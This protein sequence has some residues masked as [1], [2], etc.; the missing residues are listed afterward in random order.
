M[1]NGF[2]LADMR[3]ALDKEFAPC[4][5]DLGDEVV[6]LRNLMRVEDTTRT[7]VM[8]ALERIDTLKG[9]EDDEERQQTPEEI[10]QMSAAITE[11]LSLLPA[12]GK[13]EKLVAEIN[14]DLILSTRVLERWTEATQP[15]EATNSP[16]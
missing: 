12:N 9:D 7:K 1:S 5:V 15:G 8:K 13:G 14:G 4:P 6:V 10:E 16:A 3:A 11:V 2:S